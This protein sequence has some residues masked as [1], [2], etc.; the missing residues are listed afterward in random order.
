VQAAD[1]D[2]VDITPGQAPA[3][4]DI[5]IRN[6]NTQPIEVTGVQASAPFSIA[7]DSCSNVPIQGQASCSITVNFAPTT[8]GTSTGTLTVN[9]AAGQS[10]TQLSGTGFAELT[11][12]IT[13]V[14]GTVQSDS[15]FSCNQAHAPSR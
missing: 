15:G 6:P 11:I 1:F 12:I 14:V 8:L 7:T 3:S 2:P 4:Q 9:S 13:P 5:A 10:T